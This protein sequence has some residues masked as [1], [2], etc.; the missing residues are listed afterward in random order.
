MLNMKLELEHKEKEQLW[1]RIKSQQMNKQ[2]ELGS[3][4]GGMTNKNVTVDTS[5]HSNQT[6]I[7][8]FQ[9]QGGNHGVAQGAINNVDPASSTELNLIKQNTQMTL[10]NIKK[11][12][13]HHNN[14]EDFALLMRQPPSM[15]T[16]FGLD[17]K[18]SNELSLFDY[19]GK[20]SVLRFT[21]EQIEEI[22]QSERIQ[23]LRKLLE[24][25]DSFREEMCDC[26]DF[27]IEDYMITFKSM[28]NDIQRISHLMLRLK[29]L[30]LNS[31]AISKNISLSEALEK[32]VDATCQTLQC[33][34]AS[35]FM[36]DEMTGEL[37]TK[38]AKGSEMTI[39]IPINRGI[40]GYVVTHNQIENIEDAYKDNRFNKDVDKKNNY[41]TKTILCVPIK[42]QFGNVIGACQAIN[43]LNLPRFTSDDE[44]IFETLALNAGIIL[45]NQ[46][47]FEQS[48]VFQHKL[49]S[50]INIGI[51]LAQRTN[52]VEVLRTSERMLAETFGVERAY[53][54]LVDHENR[55]IMRYTDTGETKIFP[56]S[57]GL[58]G[59]AIQKRD[60]VS[61]SDAYNHQ[62]FNGLVDIDTSMPVIV[63]PILTL[64]QQ[65]QQEIMIT[66]EKVIANI[67]EGNDVLACIE[68][69]NKMGVVGRS[70]RNKA[71]LDPLDGEMLELF[72]K[73]FRASLLAAKELQILTGK[74]FF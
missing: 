10:A 66:G 27:K 72:E 6:L 37:W 31:Y 7:K 39:R 64:H 21:H 68:V 61:I 49:R 40:V 12:S 38:V 20:N 25:S 29:T 15:R 26:S 51:K 45:R 60:L 70:N 58:V 47:Q 50:I 16:G 19:F 67:E 73:Q 1:S 52:L 17:K 62:A 69:I 65:S 4:G 44:Y 59:L 23:F 22:L 3:L 5:M 53:I 57:A 41:R 71:S 9:T 32:I 2:F 63:K 46:I 34:R 14:G 54:Y 28:M 43:K 36:V 30:L 48:I 11:V 35:V 33:D 56:M 8:R 42:D 18:D 13:V 55:Q 24:N 74:K